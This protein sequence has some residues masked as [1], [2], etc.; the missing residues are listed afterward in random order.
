MLSWAN[1]FSIFC[2]LDNH[3]YNL[4]PHS[5]ECILAVSVKRD[6][7][8]EPGSALSDLQKFIDEKKSWLFGHLGYDLKNEMENLRSSHENYLHFP[9]TYFF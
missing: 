5:V 8:T 7:S 9:H 2:F 4:L 1:Q 3:N 6:F